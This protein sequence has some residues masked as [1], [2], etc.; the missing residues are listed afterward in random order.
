VPTEYVGRWAPDFILF[1]G[2]E[3]HSTPAANPLSSLL[4]E[5]FLV[6]SSSVTYCRQNLWIFY[7]LVHTGCEVGWAP[8]SAW[9][10]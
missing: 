5:M 8:E 3:K 4:T 6:I 10:R 2:D 9:A 7:E 1:A